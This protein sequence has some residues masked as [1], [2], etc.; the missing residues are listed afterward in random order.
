MVLMLG[1]AL[2]R[3]CA[4]QQ[5]GDLILAITSPSNGQQVPFCS[6]FS[7]DASISALLGAQPEGLPDEQIQGNGNEIY[8]VSATITIDGNA[9]LVSGEQTQYR[10]SLGPEEEWTPS[11]TLHCTGAGEV[12]I[13][14]SVSADNADTVQ[15]SVTVMQL[16]PHLVISITNPQ[17]GSMVETGSIYTL[18]AVVSNT[19]NAPAYNVTPVIHEITNASVENADAGTVHALSVNGTASQQW[20]IRCAGEGTAGITVSATGYTDEMSTTSIPDDNIEPAGVTVQQVAPPPDP[21]A[22]P[23]VEQPTWSRPARIVTT[24]VYAQPRQVLA[25]QPVTVYFNVANRGDRPGNYTATLRINGKVEEVK[26]GNLEGHSASPLQFVVSR[27]QPGNYTIDI[28]GEED[29]FTV[30]GQSESRDDV[31]PGLIFLLVIGF[32]CL[33]SLAV[34]LVRRVT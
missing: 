25:N 26:R 18:Q 24:Q 19:G 5:T 2:P 34:F 15:D 28:N 17:P 27:E 16:K 14:I 13:T 30:L 29:Y 31:K 3:D 10:S 1:L 22:A 8:N 23:V 4:A 11:W 6:N 20:T 7:V 12:A 32:L 21:F 9:E 33:A